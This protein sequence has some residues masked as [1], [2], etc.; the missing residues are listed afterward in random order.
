M[1]HLSHLPHHEPGEKVV[2]H[3]RRHWFILLKTVLFFLFL[4]ILPLFMRY[5]F[6]QQAPGLLTHEL[7]R[8]VLVL[9]T[10]IYY[11]Y[12]WAL[13]YRGFLDYYL[14]LWVVTDR[15]ILNIEQNDL[16]HRVISEHRLNKIQDVTSTQ[17][18]MFATFLDFG[19][20]RIQTAGQDPRFNFE[21]VPAPH[22]VARQVNKLIK[23]YKHHHHR[24]GGGHPHHP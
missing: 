18:G 11:L 23:N 8:P 22:A 21:Q 24:P 15:R 14:D 7:W 5:F 17:Q 1:L 6:T 20:V 9:A 10:S 4:A 13:F 16:F 2:L 3:L 12:I 19:E